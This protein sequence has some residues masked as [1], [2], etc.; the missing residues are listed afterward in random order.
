MLHFISEKE[1]I[2]ETE[3]EEEAVK[4]L[5]KRLFCVEALVAK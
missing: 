5:M 4:I 2:G 3:A 1:I